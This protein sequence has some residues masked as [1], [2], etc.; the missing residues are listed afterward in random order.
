MKSTLTRRGFLN[1]AG[2]GLGATALTCGG[3][4]AL[5]AY[6]PNVDF[7]EAQGEDP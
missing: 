6:A 1:A 4:T 3:L 5:A 7:Y 2:I